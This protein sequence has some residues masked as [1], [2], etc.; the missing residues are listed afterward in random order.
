[1]VRA[2][3]GRAGGRTQAERRASSEQRLVSALA[4]LI[5]EQGVLKT[6]LSDIG[7]RAGCSHTL[8]VHLFG[9]K[10]ALLQRLTENVEQFFVNWI[11]ASQADRNGGEALREIIASYLLFVND[12][13]P[14]YRVNLVLWCESLIGAP[15][16]LVQWRRRWDRRFHTEVTGLIRRGARDGSV[17]S[18]VEPAHLATAVVNMLRGAAIQA[19]SEGGLA[20]TAANTAQLALIDQILHG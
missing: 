12:P 14:N 9:S 8:V 18:D 6:T 20:S 5:V 2:A 7:Q 19:V 10:A 4:E 1:M 11:T 3:G 13:T 16:D 15:P 17:R